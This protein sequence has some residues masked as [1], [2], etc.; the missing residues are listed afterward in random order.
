VAVILSGMTTLEQIREN[1][2]TFSAP[3]PLN[4][5]ETALL[6]KVADSMLNLVPCTAC[7]Y[8]TE[9]CPMGLEIPRIIAAYN[10]V[11]NGDFM[12]RYDL[13]TEG[14][15]MDPRR[16]V[17]CGECA[18]ICPQGIDAPTIMG[19]LPEMMMRAPRR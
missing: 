15:A 9:G 6:T 2:R 16:C 3:E 12:A 18:A 4:P 8:C 7:R 10:G 5:E 1:V 17:T 13:D 14:D 11:K 19:A